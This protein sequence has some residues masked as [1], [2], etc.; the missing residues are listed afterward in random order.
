VDKQRVRWWDWQKD[1]WTNY[2]YGVGEMP[3]PS[4]FKALLNKTKEELKALQ[5][6]ATPKQYFAQV[7]AKAKAQA[8]AQLVEAA[9]WPGFQGSEEKIKEYL[10]AHPKATL[11]E[12]YYAAMMPSGQSTL[13]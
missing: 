10:M 1:L 8:H 6:M 5:E 9:K 4:E 13:V 12:A 11:K 7:E 3:T 2:Q